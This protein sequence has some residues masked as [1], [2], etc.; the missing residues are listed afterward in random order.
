MCEISIKYKEIRAMAHSNTVLNQITAL[1][2]RHDFEI[3]ATKHHKGQKFRSF[4]RWSQFLAMTVAQLSGRKSLRDLV[5]NIS[6]QGQRIYHLGMRR[7]SRATLARVNENQPHELYK[8]L[9]F[10]LLKRCQHSA[11]QNRFKFKGKLYLLDATTI[12]L[13]L[14]IFPWATFRKAKGAIKLHFG[15]DADGYLPAFMDMTTGKVHESSWAKALALPTGSTVVFDR[16]YNDYNWYQSLTDRK[17]TFVTRLKRD[18]DR[19]DLNKRRGRKAKWIVGDQR[20]RLKGM[21]SDLRM[22]EY[23]DPLTGKFYRFIT[24]SFELKATVITELYKE[25]WKIELFFKWIK[26]NLKV[27]TFLG[28]SPNAVLTQLWIALCVYLLLSFLKFKAKLGISLT[29]IL[30]LLQLNLFERRHLIDLLKP[31]DRYQPIVSPQLLLWSQL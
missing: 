12:D 29:A 22:V 9:F 11:P 5:T 24:N 30:R 16:G 20:I 3:L 31:P 27:K 23:V 10:S 18:A 2:S 17:I 13:C 19:Q 8:E 15:L 26:Q 14:A 6:A 25:R 28:T 7:T 21:A 4:N 1:F